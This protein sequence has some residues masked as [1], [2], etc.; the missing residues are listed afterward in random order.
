M[1]V[2]FTSDLHFGHQKDF[3][4]APRGF[5]SS[6]EADETIIQKWNSIVSCLDDV[7][8]LGDLMLGN[9]EAGLRKVQRL[10]GN[11]H[12]ILGNHDTSERIKLYKEVP[13][14]IEIHYG[15]PVKIAGYRF[16]LSHY[17]TLCGN[18]DDGKTLKRKTINLCGHTHTKD[19]WCDWDKGVI[20][21]CELDAHNCKPVEI[22]E[23]IKDLERG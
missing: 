1:S 10:N 7:Y 21:H 22:E 9:N 4:W 13:K 2:F 14:I 12:V 3:I 15:L 17:P 23:I 11:L 8:V 16:F 19:P 20:Y 6:E 5:G 18:H